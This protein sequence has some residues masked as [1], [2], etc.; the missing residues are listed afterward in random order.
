MQYFD[1][2]EVKGITIQATKNMNYF[3]DCFKKRGGSVGEYA[4]ELSLKLGT[5]VIRKETLPGSLQLDMSKKDKKVDWLT[6]V[7]ASRLDRVSW[8]EMLFEDIESL[9]Y[10]RGFNRAGK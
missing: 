9:D 1:T 4:R 6:F 7:A 5:R 8:K 2:P 3:L 10:F